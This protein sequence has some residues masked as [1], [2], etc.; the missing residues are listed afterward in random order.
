MSIKLKDLIE[1]G[2]GMRLE[3]SFRLRQMHKLECPLC[4]GSITGSDLDADTKVQSKL[5]GV[6]TWVE[7]PHCHQPSGDPNDMDWK[8]RAT[9]YLYQKKRAE[10][11][12]LDTEW[13]KQWLNVIFQ[14][15]RNLFR[16]LSRKR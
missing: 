9:T 13:K 11:N 4:K 8:V 16:K 10:F 15:D 5:F 2:L 6:S 1:G 12:K 3:P 14:T 7:C